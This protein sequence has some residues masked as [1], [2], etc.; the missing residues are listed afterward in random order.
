MQPAGED[1]GLDRRPI[2]LRAQHV[3]GVDPRPQPVHQ[4]AV[5]GTDEAGDPDVAAEGARVAGGV[6]RAA[7]HD[8]GAVV[9]EDEDRR[10]ARD[11]RGVAVEEFVGDHVADDRDPPAGE[12]LGEADQPGPEAGLT[13]LRRRTW[14]GTHG[15]APGFYRI[16]A[17][18]SGAGADAGGRQRRCI[19]SQRCG[20]RRT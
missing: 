11:P 4:L 15:R 2:A 3:R 7:G 18:A 13:A 9:L 20:S 5:A 12:P 16:A 14:R 1:A 17:A 8:D 6:A 19:H 10:L